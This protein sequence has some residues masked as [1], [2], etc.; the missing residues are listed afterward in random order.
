MA[1]YEAWE[2]KFLLEEPGKGW[3]SPDFNDSNWQTGKGAFGTRGMQSRNTLWDTKDIWVRREFSYP[4]AMGPGELFLIYS[5]DDIFELYL[6]GVQLVKTG[7]EWHNN[8]ILP[9]DKS[10]LNQE[11]KNVIAAHCH[12]RTGG[13]LV[14][15]GLFQKSETGEAFTQTAV[16]RKV[17][18]SATQTEY[19]FVCGPVDLTL[20]FVSPLLPNDLDLLSRPVSYINYTVMSNDGQKHDVQMYIEATPEWAVNHISQEVV[21]E[22]GQAE[23]VQF[24]KAGTT[25]QPVLGQKRR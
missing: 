20:E 10:L 12:N 24:L 7:Y 14:D 21:V 13:G 9:L 4:E 25:E 8:V 15:F 16:Q 6:N 3:E 18:M 22:K 2:G 11:G 17:S 23:G 1:A 19:E 5:H